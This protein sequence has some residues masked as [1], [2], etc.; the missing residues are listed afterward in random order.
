MENIMSFYKGKKDTL[1]AEQ[2][3]KGERDQK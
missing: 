1:Y 3:E 2:D